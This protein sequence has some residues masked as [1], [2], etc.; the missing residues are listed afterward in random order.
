MAFANY[1]SRTRLVVSQFLRVQQQSNAGGT[2]TD[3]YGSFFDGIFLFTDSR[4]Q[5]GLLLSRGDLVGG[6]LGWPQASCS[7]ST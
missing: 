2:D 4:A 6:L 3:R 5:V 1:P 7:Q